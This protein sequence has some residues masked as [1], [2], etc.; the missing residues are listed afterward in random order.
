[1][2]LAP[3]IEDLKELWSLGIEVYD[4][5]GKEHFQLRA[6]IF[7]TINDFPAY[8]NLSGYSTKGEKAC[9]ICEDDPHYLQPLNGRTV[10]SLV[11]HLDI[12]FGSGRLLRCT[13]HYI[14]LVCHNI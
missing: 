4:A 5:Y 10:Y 11:K 1:M 14:L 9:P 6:M 3:L 12:V 8:T 2:Y 13:I 7:C